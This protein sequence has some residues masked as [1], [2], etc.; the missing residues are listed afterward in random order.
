MWNLTDGFL[1]V[2]QFPLVRIISFIH[3]HVTNTLL[4]NDRVLNTKAKVKLSLSEE[5]RHRG[6]TGK[7]PLILNLN[8]DGDKRSSRPGRRNDLIST[9]QEAGWAPEP[10]WGVSEKKNSFLDRTWNPETFIRSLVTVL[11]YSGYG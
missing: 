5:C 4:A 11:S 7:T 10:V 8:T 3:S 9:E 6:S 1:L 2:L